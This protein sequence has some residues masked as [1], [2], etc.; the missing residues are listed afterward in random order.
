MSLGIS[1]I[2]YLLVGLAILMFIVAI[3]RSE[4][5][6]PFLRGKDNLQAFYVLGLIMAIIVGCFLI[7]QPDPNV[8]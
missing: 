7:A 1:T 3:P 6:A 8:R 4:Q 5:V 2:G